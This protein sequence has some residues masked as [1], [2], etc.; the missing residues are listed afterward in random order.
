MADTF[1]KEK[2]TEIMRSIKSKGNKS[3][4][5]ELI[6]IFKKNNIKGWRRNNKIF[7]SPDFVF[8]KS[9]LAIFTDGC[10]WHG[11]DCR[12]TRPASNTIYWYNKINRN[13]RRD[14]KVNNELKKRGWSIIRIWECEIN[15]NSKIKK[16]LYLIR[17]I[18]NMNNKNPKN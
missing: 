6:N 9:K 5:L 7:G 2:R 18:L 13:K 16:R 17:N 11:H 3:T 10:F 8:P 14:E 4:E 12:N 1:S 15:T